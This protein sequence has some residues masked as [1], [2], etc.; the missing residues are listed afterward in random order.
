[1]SGFWKSWLT[2]FCAFTALFGVVLTGGAFAATEG[3]ATLLMTLLGGSF[4]YTPALRFAMGIMG[5]VTLGWAITIYA[6]IRAADMLGEAGAPIWRLFLVAIGVW[7]VLDSLV[8]VATGF[9]LN[10]VPNTVLAAA[11]ILPVLQSGVLG[12]RAPQ[13]A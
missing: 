3:P 8:S 4:D 1:M 10:V 13:A 9:G 5:M 6:V 2:F 12:G 11:F 7:Y